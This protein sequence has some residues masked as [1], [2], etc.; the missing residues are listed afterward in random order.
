MASGR[1][2]PRPASG[3]SGAVVSC[4]GVVGWWS[5]RGGLAGTVHLLPGVGP[6]MVHAD[7]QPGQVSLRLGSGLVVASLDGLFQFGE[8]VEGPVDDWR[9][10]GNSDARHRQVPPEC[11]EPTNPEFSPEVSPG[12][13]CTSRVPGRKSLVGQEKKSCRT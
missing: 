7:T 5:R 2:G 12:I 3:P 8:P 13:P 6:A 10:R 1:A 4:G 11:G 9:L